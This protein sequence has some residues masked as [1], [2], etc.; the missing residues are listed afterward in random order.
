MRTIK[1]LILHCTATP[2]GRNVSVE[3]V[4][5][6]HRL[7]GFKCIGY[8]FLIGL[9]GEI[10][11]GRPIEQIGAHCTGR[12]QNSIGI[13]YVGGVDRNNKPKDTRTPEQK[14]ALKKLV[15][16]LKKRFPGVTV[17]GHNEYANKA[18]PSF[19]VKKEF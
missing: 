1:E 2:E 10:Q 6:K 4:D 17:H 16:D 15:E 9:K 18:C 8:H 7:R 14:Q 3:Q 5:E 11:N 12:N 13:A 19:D